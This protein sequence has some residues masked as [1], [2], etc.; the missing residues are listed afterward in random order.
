MAAAFADRNR[1]CA[2]EVGAERQV[3]ERAIGAAARLRP[4]RIGRGRRH[5]DGDVR[6]LRIGFGLRLVV[7]DRQP[8]AGELRLVVAIALEDAAAREADQDR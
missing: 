6:E 8:L 2:G 4:R 1:P 3:P 7:E 5:R